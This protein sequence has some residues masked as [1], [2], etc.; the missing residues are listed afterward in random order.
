MNALSW[1]ATKLGNFLQEMHSLRICY[2]L[3]GSHK[4]IHQTFSEVMCKSDCIS[5]KKEE[6]M[7]TTELTLQ[8]CSGVSGNK[9]CKFA[10]NRTQL[11]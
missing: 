3:Q 1:S 10:S 11:Q 5:S 6:A 2:D 7:A 8:F 9:E 4:A